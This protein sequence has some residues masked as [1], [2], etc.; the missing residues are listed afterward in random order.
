MF[1]DVEMTSSNIAFFG[2]YSNNVQKSAVLK[3][4]PINTFST[5]RKSHSLTWQHINKVMELVLSGTI[6]VIRVV[7]HILDQR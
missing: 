1:D 7:G 5:D 6:H 4:H 2:F 3:T